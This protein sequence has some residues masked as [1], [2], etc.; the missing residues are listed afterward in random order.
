MRWVFCRFIAL[1]LVGPLKW[2]AQDSN[3]E[4]LNAG[5]V[6]DGAVN[7]P[8]VSHINGNRT[9][10][11]HELN[12]PMDFVCKVRGDNGGVEVSKISNVIQLFGDVNKTLDYGI[13]V[14][15]AVFA[16]LRFAVHKG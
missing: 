10:I 11:T 14:L 1:V 8:E 5:G 12:A 2:S 16:L 4:I 7:L 6:N 13:G 9:R 3:L 15:N